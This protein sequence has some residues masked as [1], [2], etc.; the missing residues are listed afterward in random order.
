[1]SSPVERVAKLVA[2][3][4][5]PND[6]EAQAAALQACRLI[7][8][9]GLSVGALGPGADF[10]ALLDSLGDAEFMALH[11]AFSARLL[12]RFEAAAREAE[13]RRAREQRE[14]EADGLRAYVAFDGARLCIWLAER[15]A[16]ERG[17]RDQAPTH[18][19]PKAVGSF[20]SLCEQHRE[21]GHIPAHAKVVRV[22]D[23][24]AMVGYRRSRKGKGR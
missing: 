20:E 2:L 12:R 8:K 11:Q 17:A 22:P 4:G 7:R 9:H 16:W 21:L 14:A 15:L 3:T 13:E 6:N 5:S 23:E 1:M 19:F 18:A 10:G 24:E